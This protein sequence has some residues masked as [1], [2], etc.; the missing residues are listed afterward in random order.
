MVLRKLS[1]LFC[2][3]PLFATPQRPGTLGDMSAAI[4]KLTMK[5]SPAV[6]KVLVSGYSSESE[7]GRGKVAV[8]RRRRAIGSGV[9]V[10]QSGYIITNAHVVSGAQEV[11]VVLKPSAA[12]NSADG[13]GDR[14]LK[15]TIAGVDSVTDIAVLKVEAT[16]LP[17]VP[18]GD[19][20]RVHQGQFVLAF[21]SPEG[22]DDTVTI[23]VVSA[24]ARQPDPD[25]PMIYIQTDAA[26]NPGNSGGPLVDVEG[27][28]IGINT[29]ILSA[30]GGSQGINF[31]IP[32]VVVNFVYNEILM[33]GHVHR[34]V[35]G[36]YPQ[37]VSPT[38]AGGLGLREGRGLLISDVVPEGPADKAGVRLND[39]L[40]RM[41]G[42]PINT[43]PEY[44]AALYRA[45]HG[46]KVKLDLLRGKEPV[47]LDLQIAEMPQRDTD[48]LTS[49]VDPKNSLVLQLGILGIEVSGKIAEMLDDLRIESGV[50]VAAMAAESG[51]ET[52]LQPGDVIHSI[53]GAPILK[54]PELRQAL[55][56]MKPG[57]PIALQIERQ[58]RLQ[59]L[60]FELE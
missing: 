8:I 54:L 23:G 9:I 47:T 52:G 29:F 22:L 6:V 11:S 43:L 49:L 27:R 46:G 18:F 31:A 35:L 36:V 48:E 59:Y 60:A 37:M 32:S 3:V 45:P 44:Q 38:L 55:S 39:L 7:E 10:D 50:L 56:K 42:T 51:V 2:A 13:Q 19:Y 40:L 30:S 16:G 14:S 58:G 41:D 25:Q 34:R 5:V 1:L 20:N 12:Q 26:V 33:H 24:V 57:V 17:T 4:E 15:A 21:G 28:L 53:N